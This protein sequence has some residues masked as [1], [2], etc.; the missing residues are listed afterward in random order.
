MIHGVE[1]LLHVFIPILDRRIS[2]FAD[3]L[4]Q[5]FIRGSVI[6]VD[7]LLVFLIDLLLESVFF[8][9]FPS[10]LFFSLLRLVFLLR[11]F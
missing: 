9:N 10:H 2:S 8:L 3:D 4:L 7:V 1:F 11:H 5:H 6:K